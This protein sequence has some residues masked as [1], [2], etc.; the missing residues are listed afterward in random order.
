[1]PQPVLALEVDAGEIKAA[2]VEAA[3]RDSRVLGLFREPIALDGSSLAEQLR[4]FVAKHGIPADAT[5]LTALPGDLVTWRRI[6]MPFRDRKRL[7]QT[8]PFELEAQ[9]PFGLDDVVIDYH[10]LRRDKEGSSVLAALVQREDLE[11][12]LHAHQEAG[13]DPKVVDVAPLAALNALG[14]SEKP[15]PAD[16]VFVGG[17]ERRLVVAAWRDGTLAGVRNVVTAA[18]RPV[19]PPPVEGEEA[20]APAVPGSDPEELARAA[21]AE[22]RW[23][24]AAL[25]GGTPPAATPCLLWGEGPLFDRLGALLGGDAELDVRPWAEGPSRRLAQPWNQQAPGFVVALGLAQREVAPATAV[26]VNFRKGEFAYHR[27]QDELRAALWRTAALAAVVLLM[28]F[29]SSLA[30]QQRLAGRA[31]AMRSQVARVFSATIEGERPG[32][33]PVAQLRA[34]IDA[35]NKK[36]EALGD[37]VPIDGATAIDA[38]R[39]LAVAVPTDLPVDID[40]FTMDTGEIRIRATSASYETV[41]A[42]KQRIEERQYFGAV[43]VKNVKSNRDGGVAFLLLLRL[44]GTGAG[45]EGGDA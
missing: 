19:P 23:S 9:V 38:M 21:C 44:G 13:L 25:W 1:M 36:L 40:E 4:R 11:V 15:L 14:L 7:E 37:V 17:S 28:I 35:D 43:E 5:V 42:I 27:I 18:A 33:D 30:E 22:L 3:Y 41:D 29:G 32:P 12:L 39:E 31:E 20:G 26:G 45:A 2:L 10:V 8:V 34:T 24:L 16:C 6:D